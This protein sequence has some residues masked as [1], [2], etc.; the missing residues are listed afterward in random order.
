[1]AT[2]PSKICCRQ[3]APWLIRNRNTTRNR[4][5]NNSSNNKNNNRLNVTLRINTNITWLFDHFSFVEHLPRKM[6]LN[7]RFLQFC[8]AKVTQ[9]CRWETFWNPATRVLD[10]G[11]GNTKWRVK[12]KHLS[13]TKVRKFINGG[14]TRSARTINDNST[15][16][17]TAVSSIVIRIKFVG[18]TGHSSAPISNGGTTR[19]ASTIGYRS[20]H[21]TTCIVLGGILNNVLNMQ[22]HC[23]TSASYYV[24]DKTQ[25]TIRKRL[26]LAWTALK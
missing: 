24:F 2:I 8:T 25:T 5:K 6:Y 20:T 23:R 10:H 26:V 16:S 19:G 22:Y 3:R 11:V 1:M 7:H 9:W 4:N 17:F 14:G 12:S 21:I 13:S 15:S 18:G